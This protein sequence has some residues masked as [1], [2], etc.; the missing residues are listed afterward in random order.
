MSHKKQNFLKGA[1]LLGAAGILIKILGAIF[2]IPLGNFIGDRGMS[3]Y[4]SAYPIYNWL[5]VI[6]TA[7]VPTA[8]AKIISEKRAIGDEKGIDRTFKVTLVL[9]GTIGL[10]AS[11]A[12]YFGSSLIVNAVKNQPA[13]YSMRAIA[14]AIFFVSVMSVYRGY[15]QGLQQMRP[16]AL[17]QIAEQVMRVILGLSLALYLLPRGVEFAAAGATFGATAGGLAG[18][19]A[20]Y[21]MYRHVKKK[22]TT[23]HLGDH[24]E[25]SVK[26]ILGE[27]MAIAIPITIGASVLPA[28]TLIDLGIVMRRLHAIGLGTVASD[29][30]GQLGGYA[31][32]LVN[33]PQVVTAAVQISI[34]PAVA[35]LAVTKQSEDLERTVETGLRMALIIGLP[36]AMGMV[37]LAEPIMRLLYPMQLDLAE[38]TGNI[39][40]IL[41]NGVIFLSLFQV[42]TGILQ[43]LGHQRM[44]AKHLFIGALVK[45]AL[46]YVLVGIPSINILGAAISTVVAF[47]VAA[48]LNYRY[49]MKLSGATVDKRA[50]FV[51]PILDVTVMVIVVRLVFAAMFRFGNNIAAVAAIGAGILAYFLMIVVTNTLTTYDYELLPGGQKLKRLSEPFKRSR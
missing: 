25:L 37:W 6:S 42:T 28:M 45:V 50:V 23:P 36:A 43:G 46:T 7:G 29:L 4:V 17:S 31:A 41:G 15:F 44:P 32:T 27:V 51:K 30:Y 18:F 19:L 33:L 2:K 26:E 13:V 8:I 5:L 9:M 40:R 35:S 21:P 47:A 1:V 3:Y 11:L 22:D 24:R 10:F 12:L 34:V 49:V 14:P 39:L 48:V 20:I 16:Y 38:S